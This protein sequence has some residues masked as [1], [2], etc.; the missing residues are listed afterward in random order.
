MVVLN[1]IKLDDIKDG[2]VYII[3][4]RLTIL[5]NETG[6]LITRSFQNVYY[7]IVDD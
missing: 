3:A 7:E 2:D 4:T 1:E 5:G 6:S